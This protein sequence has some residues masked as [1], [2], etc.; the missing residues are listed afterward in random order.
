MRLGSLLIFVFAGAIQL[1]AIGAVGFIIY[2]LIFNP[3]LF[4]ETAARI[5][6]GF[7]QTAK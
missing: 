7:N 5:V 6:N 2:S 1:A 3:E 4:G